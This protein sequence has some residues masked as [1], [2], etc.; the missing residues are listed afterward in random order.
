MVNRAVQIA[1]ARSSLCKPQSQVPTATL[2]Q[3]TCTQYINLTDV[4]LDLHAIFSSS[5]SGLPV[6]LQ[7]HLELLCWTSA[8]YKLL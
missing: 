8:A 4:R 5:G 6:N 7:D 2:Q 1:V 3:G